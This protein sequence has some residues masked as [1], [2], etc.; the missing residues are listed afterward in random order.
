MGALA[1][2]DTASGRLCPAVCLGKD[3]W[4]TLERQHQCWT[5]SRAEEY[6]CRHLANAYV[7]ESVGSYLARRLCLVA[8]SGKWLADMV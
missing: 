8:E 2:A 1:S 6:G 5:G 7:P 3:D 4:T